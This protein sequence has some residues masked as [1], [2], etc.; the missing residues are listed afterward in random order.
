MTARRLIPL[1]RNAL[2]PAALLILVSTTGPN[3][4]AADAPADPVKDRTDAIRK[5]ITA[6]FDDLLTLYKHL[7]SH[8]ELSQH[9]VNTAAT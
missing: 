5:Q 3:P 6:Q 1:L 7:H 8:P 4:R 9:E 2:Y